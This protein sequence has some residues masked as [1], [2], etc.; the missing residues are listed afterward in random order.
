MSTNDNTPFDDDF[1]DEA[2]EDEAPFR[3]DEQ[4]P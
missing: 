2:H 1:V 3:T 4:A